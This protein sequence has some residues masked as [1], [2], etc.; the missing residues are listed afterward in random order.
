MKMTEKT[1]FPYLP[2]CNGR[3]SWG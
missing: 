1:A 3:Y 2:I